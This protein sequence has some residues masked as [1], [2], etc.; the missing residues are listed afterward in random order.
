MYWK[1]TDFMCHSDVVRA[2]LCCR[3]CR[4]EAEGKLTAYVLTC[5]VLS[6][7]G[8]S[9]LVQSQMERNLIVD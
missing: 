2:F 8:S 6:S 3:V 5:L 9:F 7:S 1:C 4:I